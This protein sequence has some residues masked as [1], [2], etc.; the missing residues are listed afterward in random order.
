MRQQ[1]GPMAAINTNRLQRMK[2]AEV[3]LKV[4]R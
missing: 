2:K 1:Y 4:K 3:E